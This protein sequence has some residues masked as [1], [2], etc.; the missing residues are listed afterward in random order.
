MEELTL[1][2][3]SQRNDRT[4]ADK[5]HSN[6]ARTLFEPLLVHQHILRQIVDAQLGAWIGVKLLDLR[7]PSAVRDK[8]LI[9]RRQLPERETL[10]AWD[11]ELCRALDG[12]ADEKALSLLLATLLDGF[13]RGM[14]PN[15]RTYVEGALLVV[16]DH[17]LAPEILAAAI[18]RIWRKDR[19]PPTISEVLDECDHAR[20]GATNARRV[21]TK[22]LALLDN[23][24][25][26]LIATGDIV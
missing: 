21:V 4:F 17:A 7:D 14:V 9:R 5:R 23:A 19:F 1:I 6:R 24:E 20:Q 18:V 25:E 12:K 3:P 15:V 10:H 13:P 8:A 2:A 22:M 11:D 26:V 16:G